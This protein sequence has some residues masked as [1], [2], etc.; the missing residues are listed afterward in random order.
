MSTEKNQRASR[1]SNYFKAIAINISSKIDIRKN[2]LN[3]LPFMAVTNPYETKSGKFDST[4]FDLKDG[5]PNKVESLRQTL[6]SQICM[7]YKKN[8][9][10]SLVDLKDPSPISKENDYRK[11]S[12][13]Y[14][15]FV[16]QE[17]RLNSETFDIVLHKNSMID[18]FATKSMQNV[19]YSMRILPPGHQ[20]SDYLNQNKSS[21]ILETNKSELIEK[22]YKEYK[23]YTLSKPQD[24]KIEVNISKNLLTKKYGNLSQ[25]KEIFNQ[26]ASNKNTNAFKLKI[27]C[28]PD[29][30]ISAPKQLDKIRY[31]SIQ[32]KSQKI[33]SYDNSKLM[34]S[35]ENIKQTRARYISNKTKAMNSGLTFKIKKTASTDGLNINSQSYKKYTHGETFHCKKK[36]SQNL[37]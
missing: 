8:N 16:S 33:R 6:H 17:S 5:R 21:L 22:D 26:V 11:D 32:E 30:A 24:R 12:L 7:N 29:F 28:C 34:K 4:N 10:S 36:A 23:L 15:P 13:C 27:N 19:N 20:S 25:Q 1:V 2:S 3:H 37:K 14:L 18:N 35:P 9:Q 31:S